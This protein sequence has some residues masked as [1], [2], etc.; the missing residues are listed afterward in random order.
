VYPV[1]DV[2]G[3]AEWEPEISLAKTAKI[4]KAGIQNLDVRV[5][6]SELKLWFSLAILAIL[7][8]L[9]RAFFFCSTRKLTP[10]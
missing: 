1:H 10:C 6:I 3:G 4:A 7:A 8:I 5:R 2:A 9:A